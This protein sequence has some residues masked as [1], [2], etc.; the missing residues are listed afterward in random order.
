MTAIT[1]LGLLAFFLCLVVTPIVRD[2]FRKAELVD[3]PD[4]QRK[5]HTTPIPRVGGIPIVVSYTG[6][7]ALLFLLSPHGVKLYIQH[8]RLLLSLLPATGIMF[9][10][11]LVDDL[12]T[13]RPWQKLLGQSFAAGLAVFLGAHLGL[14]HGPAWLA[15]LISFVWLVACA[16]ALNLIDGMD[17]LAS[18]VALFAT[19][20]TMIAA[21]LGGNLGLAVAT[22]PL[23]GCLFAFLRYNFHPATIFLGDC[24]SLTIGFMLGCFG[25]IWSQRTGTMLGLAAPLMALALPL[26]DVALAVIRRF[27]RSVPIFQGD[28]GHIHHMVLARGLTTRT[29]VL[30]LYAVCGVASVMALMLSFSAHQFKWV[31]SLVF[32]LLAV[33]GIN[34]LGYSEISAVLRA[35][36]RKTM[37]RLIQEE[38]YLH[39]LDLALRAAHTVEHFWTVAC[40]ACEDLCF[41]TV[42][43]KLDGKEF[44]QVMQS[45]TRESS[46]RLTVP[47]GNTGELTLT[48]IT[49]A[50][51]PRLTMAVIERLQD[52]SAA[53]ERTRSS[54]RKSDPQ[55]MF[56]YRG[57]A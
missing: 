33:I 7:L 18:G 51:P 49:E 29:A 15:M 28:R 26:I 53:H 23:A 56:G 13:L 41:A 12:F 4:Q 31:I 9:L 37:L 19:V 25:L 39:E 1:T 55:P 44:L 17:G 16:N 40:T 11:G 32:C 5:F 14:Q 43:I 54:V 3:R 48:R 50:V 27:L 6:S 47:L 57:A 8:S 45:G 34:N 38:I 36:S 35:L 30:V 46:W 21:I 52:A 42:C 20:A 22:V 24:G 2:I 10:T